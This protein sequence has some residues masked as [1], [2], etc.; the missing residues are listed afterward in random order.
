MSLAYH[1]AVL[2]VLHTES[3]TRDSIITLVSNL[4]GLKFGLLLLFRNSGVDYA[5]ATLS[6]SHH[7]SNTCTCISGVRDTRYIHWK[8]PSGLKFSGVLL[9]QG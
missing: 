1:S 4:V 3:N 5:I 2:G 8:G 9:D 6:T 7:H